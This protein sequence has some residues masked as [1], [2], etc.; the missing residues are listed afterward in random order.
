MDTAELLQVRLSL[1]LEAVSVGVRAYRVAHRAAQVVN[2][3]SRVESN[4]EVLVAISMYV[5][6]PISISAHHRLDGCFR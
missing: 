5:C 3:V 2:R 4:K 1:T 6:S